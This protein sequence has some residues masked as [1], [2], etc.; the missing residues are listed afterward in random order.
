MEPLK[1]LTFRAEIILVIY[2]GLLMTGLLILTH[3][4]SSTAPGPIGLIRGVTGA[5]SAVMA[6]FIASLNVPEATIYL[7]MTRST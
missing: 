2:C 3:Q 5:L 6:S 4:D 1:L 7:Y